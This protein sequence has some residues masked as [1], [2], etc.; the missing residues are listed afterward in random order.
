MFAPNTNTQLAFDD[1]TLGLTERERRVLGNSWAQVFRD[2]IF[3]YIDEE[4]FSVIYSDAYSRPNAPANVVF[5]ELVKEIFRLS[6]D[7]LVYRLM[8][9]VS[10]QYA[11]RGDGRIRSASF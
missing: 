10:F 11:P 5:G 9:D 3:P 8:F 6:D 7:E 2:E 1:S 4:P